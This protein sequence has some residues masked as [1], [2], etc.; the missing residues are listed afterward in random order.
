MDDGADFAAL[1]V[2]EATGVSEV[3]S[4][5]ASGAADCKMLEIETQGVILR[6]SPINSSVLV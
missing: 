3:V 6:L 5:P 4:E 1:L 2:G